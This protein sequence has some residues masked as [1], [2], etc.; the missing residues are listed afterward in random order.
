MTESCHLLRH[1]CAIHMHKN[2]DDIR[3]ISDSRESHPTAKNRGWDIFGGFV[4]FVCQAA[5]HIV[6]KLA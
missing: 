6:V 4:C 2:E 3:A 5:Y 1:G